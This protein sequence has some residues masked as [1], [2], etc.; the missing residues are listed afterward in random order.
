LDYEEAISIRFGTFVLIDDLK[1]ETCADNGSSLFD[2]AND[3]GDFLI[4]YYCCYCYYGCCYCCDNR[5][6]F[7]TAAAAADNDL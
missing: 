4:G 3:D 6:N 2:D 5:K 7:A 1:W